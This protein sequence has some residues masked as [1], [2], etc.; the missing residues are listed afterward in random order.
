[1]TLAGGILPHDECFYFTKW[2]KKHWDYL[3]YY[4]DVKKKSI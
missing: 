2:W 4:N 3:K 1:M